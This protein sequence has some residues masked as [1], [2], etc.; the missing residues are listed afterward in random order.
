MTPE[1]L[2]TFR[3]YVDEEEELYLFVHIWPSQDDMWAGVPGYEPDYR[4]I[5][6]SHAV[7]TIEDAVIL[8]DF[9][10]AEMHL[11]RGCFGVGIIAHELMHFVLF[12]NM[13]H[14]EQDEEV[15]CQLV[16]FVNANFWSAFYALP[17]HQA[18]MTR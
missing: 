10:V 3:V 16:G 13:V 12:W 14:N 4:A 8:D 18:L 15:I 6:I 5:T 11:I 7:K 1:E 2:I 9:E 17:H